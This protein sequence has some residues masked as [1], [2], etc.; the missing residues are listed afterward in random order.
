MR[1][2]AGATPLRRSSRPGLPEEKETPALPVFLV[3]D[4]ICVFDHR[5]DD[6]RTV[7]WIGNSFDLEASCDGLLVLS[8]LDAHGEPRS[9]TLLVCN[10]ATHEQASLRCPPWDFHII[11]MYAHRPTGEYRLLLQRTIDMKSSEGQTGCYVLSLGSKEPP[12]YI[13]WPETAAW[14]FDIPVQVHDSLHW[15]SQIYLSETS[16]QHER[17]GKPV[18]VFDTVAE[19][20]RRMCAPIVSTQAHIFDMDGMLG[21]YRRNYATKEIDVE[22]FLNEKETIDIWVLR[23]YESEVWDKKYRIK[24]PLAKIRDQ[25]WNHGEYC[26]DV[27]AGDDG[28]LVLLLLGQ[29]LTRVDSDGELLGNFNIGEKPRMTKWRLKQSLV[30]HTFFSALEGYAVKFCIG[31]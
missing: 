20:F 13:G 1:T 12:R 18:I 26:L 14:C 17:D 21:I 28:V 9:R 4:R 16:P 19:S 23:N 8:K 30:Q 25:F 15:Y 7:A 2:A 5:A 27:V 24:L 11:G 6:V 29:Y 22:P 10:P 3:S 31:G